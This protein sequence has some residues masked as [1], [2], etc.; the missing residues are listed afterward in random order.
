MKKIEV[1]TLIWLAFVLLA[2]A[3]NSL[4]CR[5]ALGMGQI[6]PFTFTAV[7]LVSG[8]VTLVVL[9][10]VWGVPGGSPAAPT[11]WQAGSWAGALSL[12]AY[13]ILFSLAYVQLNT[14]TGALIQFAAVQ[15]CML[16]Y[17]A[18]RGDRLRGWRAVGAAL[19]ALGLMVLL[20]PKA[21]HPDS[22]WAVLSMAGAGLSWGVYSIVG[23]GSRFPLADTGG[24]FWRSALLIAV[25]WWAHSVVVV[26]PGLPPTWGGLVLALASG[27]L[28]SGVGYAV[29]YKVLPRLPTSSAAS[30]QLAVPVLAAVAGIV[31]LS[32]PFEAHVWV[33][34]VLTLAGIALVLRARV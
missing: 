17:A 9:L 21:Q 14:A 27:C 10:G 24:N 1:S 23:R 11:V 19:A 18:F 13:A 33:A 26:A 28:A 29:W 25:L 12:F 31:L 34:M 3:S 15:F 8:A 16:A 5:A 30:I 32:E 4:L 2:F 20:A 7:R 6:D 22:V